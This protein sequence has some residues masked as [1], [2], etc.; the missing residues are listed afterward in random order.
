MKHETVLFITLIASSTFVKR[1]QGKLLILLAMSLHRYFKRQS[2][3]NVTETLATLPVVATISEL[4]E[5]EQNEDA[6]AIT[7]VG[8]KRKHHLSYKKYDEK[9]RMEI[10]K[11]TIQCSNKDAA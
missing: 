9:Q 7:T 11:H 2:K 1:I 8:S 3:P 5:T 6:D 10:T 4:T